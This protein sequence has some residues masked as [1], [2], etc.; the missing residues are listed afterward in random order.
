MAVHTRRLNDFYATSRWP[1]GCH[2]LRIS[3]PAKDLSTLARIPVI[4]DTQRYPFADPLEI[5]RLAD[6]YRD[7]IIKEGYC[8]LSGFLRPGAVKMLIDEA[9]TLKSSGRGFRSHEAHNVFLEKPTSL[10]A[11]DSA[12]GKE[13]HS[14]KV[15]V[16]MDEMPVDSLLLELYRWDPLRVFLQSVFDLPQLFLS[17]DPLGGSYF[18]FFEG[19]CN[20]ALGW[21]FDKSNFSMN[22]ILQTTPGAG[23]DFQFVPNSRK[24]IEL[25]DSWRDCEQ[26]ILKNVKTPELLPGSLYLFAGSR[27]IHRVSPVIRGERINAIFTYFE[28]KGTCLNEYTLMKFFGRTSPRGKCGRR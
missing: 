9:N 5:Q 25:L 17:A 22:L 11:P 13:F 18:N 23:G 26:Y 24:Q 12:I 4:V 3:R 10:P 15:L 6:R 20:D 27:S 8:H 28:K 2:R 16:A 14:S 7:V 1:L 21:H 19:S